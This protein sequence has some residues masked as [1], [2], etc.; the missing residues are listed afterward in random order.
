MFLV[1]SIPVLLKFSD[2]KL[3]DLKLNDL[4]ILMTRA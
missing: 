3:S 2:L 1:L 4:Q